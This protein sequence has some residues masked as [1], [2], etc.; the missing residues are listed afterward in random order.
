MGGGGVTQCRE[1]WCA[2]AHSQPFTPI[3]VA[4]RRSWWSPTWPYR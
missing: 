4:V 3:S 1:I 2:A